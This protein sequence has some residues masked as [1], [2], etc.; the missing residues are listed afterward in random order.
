VNRKAFVS[1]VLLVVFGAAHQAV[2][3]VPQTQT[4]PSGP[5]AHADEA[6]LCKALQLSLSDAAPAGPEAPADRCFAE[7]QP[8]L[9]IVATAPNP[10]NSQLALSFDRTIDDIQRAAG[11]RGFLFDRFVF[12]WDA[13][14]QY[15]QPDADKRRKEE[16]RRRESE[17]KP[18]MLLFRAPHVVPAQKE[19]EDEHDSLM[20][21]YRWLA[22][23]LVPENPSSGVNGE[24]FQKAVTF[25]D[26]NSKFRDPVRVLGPSFSNSA[27]SLQRAMRVTKLPYQIRTGSATV[28]EA[29]NQLSDPPQ[30]EFR[31]TVRDDGEASSAL[32]EHLRGKWKSEWWRQGRIAT[33]SE[34]GTLY[35]TQHM[36]TEELPLN[37]VFPRGISWLRNAY[38]DVPSAVPAVPAGLPSPVARLLPFAISE[39]TRGDDKPPSLSGTQ[40]PVSEEAA[41]LNIATTLRRERARFV[42]ITGTDP[43]DNIF[44]MRFL[45]SHCPD[46]RLITFEADLLYVRAAA[47]FPATGVILVTTYPLFT[48]S[49]HWARSTSQSVD[50]RV[51]FVSMAS[52]GTYNACK[53][54]FA[55]A[56]GKPLGQDV[57]KDYRDPFHPECRKPPVW[58]TVTTAN[59]YWPLA[60]L[61]DPDFKNAGESEASELLLDWPQDNDAAPSVPPQAE[62]ASRVWYVI[63]ILL[64]AACAALLA[65][66]CGW[67]DCGRVPW[68]RMFAPK[69]AF[70]DGRAYFRTV[71]TLCLA[72]LAMVVAGPEL[73]LWP[74]LTRWETWLAWPVVATAL[75]LAVVLAIREIPHLT[76]SRASVGRLYRCMVYLAFLLFLISIAI[77]LRVFCG[78]NHHEG[79][80]AAYRSLDLVN[81]VAPNLPFALL[82]FA[83]LCWASVHLKR[84]ELFESSCHTVPEIGGRILDGSQATRLDGARNSVNQALSLPFSYRPLAYAAAIAGLYF[85][86]HEYTQSLELWEFDVVYGCLFA[87]VVT[88]L[89]VTGARL[90]LIWTRLSQ[91]L[92]ILELHPIRDTFGKIRLAGKWGPILH[93]SL[94]EDELRVREQ[95]LLRRFRG[96]PE[97]ATDETAELL[98]ERL[99]DPRW[100]EGAGAGPDFEAAAEFFALRYVRFIQA[101]CR[102]MEN[103]LIFISIGFVLMLI[104][105][106][107]YPFQSGHVLGWFL[108]G[109]LIV[110]GAGVVALL[111]GAERDPILSRMNGTTPGSLGK[112]FYLNVLSY[113]ALPLLTVLAVQ[114]P[115]LGQF[116][117]SWV[118][119]MLQ[120][121]RG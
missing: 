17:A 90:L 12:P 27:D 50:D 85:V 24:A 81:G 36:S 116:L 42:V 78:G 45:G 73:V 95:E 72:L 75:A 34:S 25:V 62:D 48:R 16:L 43:L 102:Q 86:M 52:D 38:Q 29:W 114:F 30:L 58:L 10:A 120:A 49:Q 117:F 40:T 4:R 77:W 15:T 65:V 7:N 93:R 103:L 11:D 46:V 92:R 111:A 106:N 6:P 84:L 60:L 55:A 51:P 37:L 82:V 35:G 2:N 14:P 39:A 113:G 105:L 74:W 59:G 98:R 94:G 61:S 71:A 47:E 33:L 5:A 20:S 22:V 69:Q 56:V 18:G 44:L 13:E 89:V 41:L 70:D 97:N 99:L 21:K 101:A 63:T 112:D 19:D 87:V 28:P 67:I 54:L 79:F 23:L 104:S 57:P 68:M 100:E 1:A 96:G 32:F 9:F 66:R 53:S 3:T 115:S 83:I 121:M 108:T 31:A 118:Q 80:F 91:M 88:T 119:P 109:F 110:L 8:I 107:S 26:R 64:F 76:K